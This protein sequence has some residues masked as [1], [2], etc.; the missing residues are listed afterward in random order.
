[1]TPVDR[2]LSGDV[3]AFDLAAEMRTAR[4]ELLSGPG[5]GGIHRLPNGTLAALDGGVRQRRQ[6]TRGRILS[7]HSRWGSESGGRAWMKQALCPYGPKW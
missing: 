1:M 2:R 4:E 7:P 6:L 5:R 3:L